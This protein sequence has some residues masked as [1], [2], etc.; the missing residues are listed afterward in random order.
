MAH[1]SIEPRTRKYIKGYGFLLFTKNLS[2]KYGKQI[3]DTA[4]GTALDNLKTAFKKAVHKE[5]AAIGEFI[6]NKTA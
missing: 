3:L 6:G 2:N 4:I 5:V 1:R